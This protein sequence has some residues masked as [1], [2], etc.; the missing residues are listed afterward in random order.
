MKRVYIYILLTY[1]IMQLSAFVGTPLL[2]VIGIF[3]FGADPSD[4]EALAIAYWS[5]ISFIIGLVIILLFVKKAGPVTKLDADPPL[6]AGKSV[7][8][9][10][11]GVFMAFL[12][13]YIAAMMEHALGIDPASANTE[14]LIQTVEM[15]PLFIII[16]SLIGPIL[17]EIVFRKVIFGFLY[18]RFSFFLSALMS[19]LIFAIVHMDPSHIIVYSAMGF[20]FAFLYMKT[21]RIIVPIAAHFMMNTV[22]VLTQV[23][24]D[25]IMK[26][27][28]QAAVINTALGG[29]FL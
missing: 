2:Y 6:P 28:E 9:A 21:R 22:A 16:T 3:G 10:L 11:A 1:I 27:L 12:S 24:Q 4:M 23:N 26:W 19:S 25:A 7:I 15:V 13:Q 18:N 20:T 14:T 17:E 5:I 29:F 8:W